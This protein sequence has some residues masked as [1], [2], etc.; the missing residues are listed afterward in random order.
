MFDTSRQHEVG[1]VQTAFIA[2]PEVALLDY[3]Q[4]A[5]AWAQQGWLS[6]AIALCKVILRLEPE[7][8]PARR[9]LAELDARRMESF[10]LSGPAVP[11]LEPMLRA[12]AAEVGSPGGGRTS[13]FS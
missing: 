13:L 1:A 12:P 3:E 5:E 9:L 11:K 10:A 7:H 6:R 4:L 2:P 8:E